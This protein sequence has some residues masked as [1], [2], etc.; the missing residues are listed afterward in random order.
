MPLQE[1][2]PSESESE[3]FWPS[4]AGSEQHDESEAFW[5]SEPAP[6]PRR[7]RPFDLRSA[8][9]VVTRPSLLH[10]RGS[11]RREPRHGG[12]AGAVAGAAFALIGVALGALLMKTQASQP[13]LP[14]ASGSL[15]WSTSWLTAAA[16]DYYGA[17]LCLCGVIACSEPR[18]QAVCWA[19][20]CCFLGAPVCCLYVTARLTRY[21]TLELR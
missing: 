6:L 7:F 18:G 2:T 1:H 3:A 12:P 21:G 14:L 11:L 17:C 5:P 20:G 8:G 15:E 13:L 10:M 4:V 16:A 9:A 19:L